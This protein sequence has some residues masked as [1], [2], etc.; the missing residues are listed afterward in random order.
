MIRGQKHLPSEERLRDLGLFSPEKRRLRGN[1][2]NTCK[3]LKGG[4]QDDGA[5]FFSAVPNN[6]TK[7]N[8]HKLEHRKFYLNMRKTFPVR[9]TEQWH[10][11]LREVMESSSLETFKTHLDVVLCPLL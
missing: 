10:R 11:L 7:G 6:K 8:R 4:C 2:N 3:Y 9:V 5:R 1:H